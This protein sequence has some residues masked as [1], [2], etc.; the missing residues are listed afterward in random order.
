MTTPTTGDSVTN[1]ARLTTEIILSDSP[2]AEVLSASALGQRERL[3]QLL[4]A[5]PAWPTPKA[6]TARPPAPR[7]AV[8][9]ERDA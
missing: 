6:R 4:A 8:G 2:A 3:A 7:R 5:D 1:Q 9:P